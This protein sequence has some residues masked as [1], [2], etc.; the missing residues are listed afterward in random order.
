METV[1]QS[2]ID[3]D[4]IWGISKLIGN[5]DNSS[6]CSFPSFKELSLGAVFMA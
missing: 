3:G 1:A 4:E 5:I 2:L 6:P